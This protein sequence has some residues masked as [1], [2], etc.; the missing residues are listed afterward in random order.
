[1]A[2][3]PML[4]SRRRTWRGFIRLIQ[5]SLA[6]TVLALIFMAIFLL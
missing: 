2:E 1:M 5:F 3:D 4:E 6:A